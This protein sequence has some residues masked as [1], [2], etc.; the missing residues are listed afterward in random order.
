MTLRTCLRCDWEGDTLESACPNCG[1]HLYLVGAA[2][3][4]RDDEPPGAATS[5]DRN[6]GARTERIAPSD[7]GSDPPRPLSSPV[8]TTGSSRRPTRSTGP[9]VLGGLGLTLAMG[10][11]LGAHGQGLTLEARTDPA[12]SEAPAVH[13]SPTPTFS[14]SPT[15]EGVGP[16]QRSHV[17]T[18]TLRIDGVP[19]SFTIRRH[20]W[21]RFGDISINKSIVG[22]QGAEAMIFFTSFPIG[23]HAD[24][25]ARLKS[26]S[27]DSAVEDLAFAVS[28][29]PGIEVVS[30]PSGVTVGG[31]AAQHVVLT[32]LK[33]LGCDPGYFYT[34][35]DRRTGALWPSTHAGDTIRVWIVQVRGTIVFIEAENTTQASAELEHEIEQIV[36]SIE[37]A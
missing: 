19:L 2:P 5:E 13:D 18:S 8:E 7:Y 26:L 14:P 30:G 27:V 15:P 29:A 17:G 22:P 1:V 21:E 37:F 10:F 9:F 34:W 4:S 25:C 35:H 16:I 28:T 12:L 11:W 6:S 31:R 33:D 24:R 36:G 3:A 23:E 32:V 20:G